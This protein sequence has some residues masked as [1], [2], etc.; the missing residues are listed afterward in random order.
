LD[1]FCSLITQKAMVDIYYYFLYLLLMYFYIRYWYSY[2]FTYYYL[3]Y[4]YLYIIIYE[5]QCFD[6]K[7]HVCTDKS[8]YYCYK[9]SIW[10][11]LLLPPY[12]L[13]HNSLSSILI[14]RDSFSYLHF[15]KIIIKLLLLIS[16][17]NTESTIYHIF[18]GTVKN[19]KK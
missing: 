11:A 9:L 3:Y 13:R 12:F 4:L 1:P 18:L 10:T 17:C 6:I 14:L 15:N 7:P 16:D 19:D 2:I 8:L 5:C